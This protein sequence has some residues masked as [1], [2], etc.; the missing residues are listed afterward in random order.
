MTLKQGMKFKAKTKTLQE[1]KYLY[2]GKIKDGCGNTRL[3]YNMTLKDYTV[4]EEQWICERK[5]EMIKQNKKQ[6]EASK[7]VAKKRKR[8]WIE[9]HANDKW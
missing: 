7:G 8:R 9:N 1:Y 3:L 4:V 5:I 6:Y 2:L